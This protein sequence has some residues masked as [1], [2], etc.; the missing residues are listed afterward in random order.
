M[1]FAKFKGLVEKMASEDNYNVNQIQALISS[2]YEYI[3]IPYI[4]APQEF[5]VRCSKNEPGEIFKN[6]SRCSYNPNTKKIP[7][8]RCNY[9]EQQ[10]FYCSMFSDTD[11]ATTTITCLVETAWDYIE[12]YGL[13]YSF[14][15]LSRWPLKRHMT[16]WALPF[17]EL[18]CLR[19]RDFKK[20]RDDIETKMK[21]QPGNIN[22]TIDYLQYMSDVFCKRENKKK[23]YKISS[24]FFNYLLLHRQD[25]NLSFDGLVY[26]SANTEGAGM[27]VAIRKE[28]IDDRILNCDL[29]TVWVM[30]RN[31]NDNKRLTTYPIS[32]NSTVS[33]DGGFYFIPKSNH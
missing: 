22:E 17:S 1:E 16:L 21:G 20:I 13:S 25:K 5:V 12:N 4:I 31:P 18:G 28:L 19:N 27:N 15:T 6:V 14:F 11:Y 33:K 8:Q 3:Q 23:Y 32:N 30:I 2:C 7:L 26:P 9:K 10:A 29:A 24:A